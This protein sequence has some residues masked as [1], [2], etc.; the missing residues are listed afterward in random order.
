MSIE[1][2]RETFVQ[3]EITNHE[4]SGFFWTAEHG[5][6]DV[7]FNGVYLT[8][9]AIRTAGG[10]YDPVVP[11]LRPICLKGFVGKHIRGGRTWRATVCKMDGLDVFVNFGPSHP[12]YSN[13]SN[14]SYDPEAYDKSSY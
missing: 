3:S 11:S 9:E 13:I 10:K 1:I 8:V 4:S 14:V 12:Y 7:S 2:Y 6:V 5:T